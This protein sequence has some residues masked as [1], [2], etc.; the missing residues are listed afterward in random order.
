MTDPTSKPDAPAK[1][2]L[3]RTYRANIEDLWALWTTPDGFEAWWGPEGFRVAV[4]K[5]DLRV[6]GEIVYDMIAEDPEVIAVLRSQ[7]QAARHG[8]R[9]IFTEIDA[10]RRLEKVYTID[11]IKGV[12]PYENGMLLELF[13]EEGGHVRMVVTVDAHPNPLW[14][15]RAKEGF[16]S[17]LTKL[18]AA[19]EAW[20]G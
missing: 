10:P 5:L 14:T 8:T 19:L 6:G 11:F 7:G 3:E 9:A 1:I 20:S 13:E 12:A 15:E 16:E 18:P 2:W 17:Q 4:R